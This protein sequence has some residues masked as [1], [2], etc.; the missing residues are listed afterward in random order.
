MTTAVDRLLRLVDAPDRH[1]I[2]LAD[3]L[4]LQ[5]EAANERLAAHSAAIQL[6]GARVAETGVKTIS[7]SADLVPLLFAHTAYKSYPEGW[8][9][10]GRWELLG[11][12][13][14]SVSVGEM[15][16][17]D[18]AEVAGIDDWLA[19][20]A[21]AGR[22]V[23]CSSGTSGKVSMIPSLMADRLLNKRNLV[24]SLGW[25][26]GLKPDNQHRVFICT[27]S[28]NN[29]RY[30]DSWDALAG[31]FGHEGHEFSFPG[32]PVTVGA[33]RQMVGLRNAIA[34]GDARP[35]DLAAYEALVQQREQMMSDAVTGIAE[36]LV[37]S[38][39]HKLMFVGMFGLMFEV[40]QKVRE[41]GYGRDDFDPD[42][43]MMVSGGLKGTDLPPDYREQIMEIF[44]IAPA[45]AFS[46]YGMQE[47]NTLFPRCRAGRYHIA[48]WVML[49]PLDEAGEQ[50]V[51]PLRGELEGRAAFFDLSHEGRWGGLISGDKI[52]VDYDRCACGHEGPT[53]ADTIARYSDLAGGDKI[54]CA[55]T[56]D[57]YVRGGA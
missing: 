51:G 30:L 26:T 42:N 16:P 49:L 9:A 34:S 56:I 8:L 5:M 43:A 57:A 25:S 24:F 19:R 44:N 27:P 2:P 21:Q 33:I 18:M 4:P 47:L 32:D 55:G 17:V 53:V 20:L 48:P 7:D 50:L 36:Q 39:T 3:L 11:R 22:Y 41:M 54:S 23:S 28:G 12:W 38:R 10:N 45:R 1:T 40:A 35:E 46:M 13:L 15:G 37:V 14:D 29:F 52:L 6:V 31:A